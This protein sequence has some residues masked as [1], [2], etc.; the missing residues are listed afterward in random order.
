MMRSL[1][2]LSLAVVTFG[3]SPLSKSSLTKRFNALEADM[4]DH[5]GFVLYDPAKK[6]TVFAFNSSRYFTPASNTKIF[7]LFASLKILGDSIPA[8]HYVET[9][10]SL[11]FWGTGDPSLL[12]KD[13]FNDYRVYEFLANAKQPLYFSSSNFH[14]S[15]FGEGWSWDDYN[16]HYSSE[17]SPFPVYGNIM[18]MDF[19]GDSLHVTPPYFRKF[20]SRGETK[21]TR[22]VI[23]EV[24]ANDFQFHAGL[25]P[26][27]TKEWK[28]P[29]RLDQQ[30]ITEMLGDTI[31]KFVTPILKPIP[32]NTKTIYS[33]PA[34]SLYRVMMQES[35]NFIA[36][37]LLL[38]CSDVLS[39]TLQPEIAIK[40][41]KEN[42]LNDLADEPE[43]VDGS[44]LSRYNLFT[45][46]SVVQLWEKIYQL[47]PRER[48]FPLLATGGVNGTVKNWYKGDRQ[49]FLF[50]K[51]GSLSNVHCLSGFIVTKSGKTVIFSFMN[52]NFVASTNAV[53]TQMQD[54]IKMIYET[55]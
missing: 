20:Y 25:K 44:G 27:R 1:F 42:L 15:H 23:R 45:P 5:T 38:L 17:R 22:Q 33:I 50:G 41:V 43:W 19:I 35:D 46:R 6:K 47:V 34:D 48:L 18:R 16:T 53:R 36:E 31:K 55:Y 39:D 32:A 37:Q 14:T 29:F 10:D 13:V 7:T 21:D 9:P 2:L 8:L 4:Q 11:I 28:I 3:C 24:H 12:Y 26:S 30:V 49:P 51:T 54:I 40:Y 52:N